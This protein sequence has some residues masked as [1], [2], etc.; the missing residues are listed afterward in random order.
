MRDAYQQ[1]IIDILENTKNVKVID[2]N[3][4]SEC[5]AKTN[6]VVT[7]FSSIIFDLMYRE[8]PF[9]IYV[10]DSNDPNITDIYTDDYIQLIDR[11][12]NGTFKTENKCESVEETVE[13]LFTILKRNSQ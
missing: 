6:L 3:D 8:K 5:L 10:P 7:D 1:T 2:Q 9:V 4:I 11:M 13:K 12:N